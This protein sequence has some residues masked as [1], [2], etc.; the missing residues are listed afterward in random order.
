MRTKK[1]SEFLCSKVTLKIATHALINQYGDLIKVTPREKN[2]RQHRVRSTMVGKKKEIL[3]NRAQKI[4]PKYI[5]VTK[6]KS[7]LLKI[8]NIEKTYNTVPAYTKAN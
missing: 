7:T 5:H 4:D 3:L 2:C 6:R 8:P 1:E